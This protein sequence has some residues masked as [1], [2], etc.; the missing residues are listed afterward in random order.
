MDRV[1]VI[2]HF[3]S[4]ASESG[5][6]SSPS[7]G[8]TSNSAQVSDF[9]WSDLV[10]FT[11]SASAGPSGAEFNRKIS[12]MMGRATQSVVTMEKLRKHWA[13]ALCVAQYWTGI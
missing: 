7:E 13:I 11:V 10:Q 1:P 2:V 5:I 4:Q 9:P 6:S 3:L 8:I 12:I